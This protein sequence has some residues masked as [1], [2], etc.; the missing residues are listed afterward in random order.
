MVDF[1]KLLKN[2]TTMGRVKKDKTAPTG[3]PIVLDEQTRADITKWKN[4][5]EWMAIGKAR[6]LELRNKLAKLFFE[7]PVEGTNRRIGPG[8]EI[9]L[10]HKIN[11][12]LNKETLDAVMGE[13]YKLSPDYCVLG[14]PNSLIKFVPEF[15]TDILRKLPKDQL[16]VFQQTLTESDGTPTLEIILSEV[17]VV[18]NRQAAHDI[19]TQVYG[20]PPLPKNVSTSVQTEASV[21]AKGRLTGSVASP[22]K[23]VGASK[24]SSTGKPA[25]S[26]PAP[27]KAT[28]KKWK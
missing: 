27:K 16:K 14:T 24:K 15:S 25:K 26:K 8:V 1:L 12:V 23:K 9:S 28:G 21:A 18:E 19:G 22:S 5:Q 6:E 13:L 17:A 3:E 4:I 2:K 10:T 7:K 11:R 20:K